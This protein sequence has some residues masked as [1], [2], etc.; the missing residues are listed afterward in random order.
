MAQ[1]TLFNMPVKPQKKAQAKAQARK[2][3]EPIHKPQ[4][5]HLS[6]EDQKIYE[7]IN[8]RRRQMLV[9][10]CLYYR[11]NENLITDQQFNH[12][13][14]ELVKLQAQYPEIAAKVPYAEAF[15]DWDASTGFHLPLDDPWV[16][17]TASYLLRISRDIKKEESE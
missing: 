11:M 5:L 13:G 3:Q 6:P 1:K 7:L 2:N 4:P 8:R 15:S 10:S 16:T 14:R 17:G 9:H 12:W